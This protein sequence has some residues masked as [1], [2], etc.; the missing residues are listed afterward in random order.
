MELTT[1]TAFTILSMFMS[2]SEVP[3]T[4]NFVYNAEME[5]DKI[6]AITT[7]TSD[8]IEQLYNKQK[9]VY[10]YDQ[11]GRVVS[12]EQMVWSESERQWLPS[13]KWSYSYRQLSTTVDY[14]RWDAER[15][16]YGATEQRLVYEGMADCLLSVHEYQLDV[17]GQ[18][19]L[20]DQ[21][22]MMHSGTRHLLAMR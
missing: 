4:D 7:Y 19:Q 16:R 18:M 15:Q 17:Q 10:V 21:F 11:V 8:A 22:L 2:M 13:R 3:T 6:T 5:G 20:T 14:A 12:K 1:M 9:D